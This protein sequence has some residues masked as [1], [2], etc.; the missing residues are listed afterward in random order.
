MLLHR[1]NFLIVVLFSTITAN[2]TVLVNAPNPYP[3][4]V[5]GD[6]GI[7][8]DYA[9]NAAGAPAVGSVNTVKGYRVLNTSVNAAAD[10]VYVDVSSDATFTTGKTIG[11]TLVNLSSNSEITIAGAG[12][13]SGMGPPLDCGNSNCFDDGKAAIYTQSTTLRISF[14]LTALC[15]TVSGDLCTHYTTLSN[16]RFTQSI[17]VHFGVVDNATI[18]SSTVTAATGTGNSDLLSS[19]TLAVSD[20]APV[21]SSTSCPANFYF[22]GDT[23]IYFNTGL[24]TASVGAT[25]TNGTSGAALQYLIAMANEVSV[26]ATLDGSTSNAIISYAPYGQ[27]Q[28]TIAG[29]TNTTN[30]TDHSYLMIVQAQNRAGIISATGSS[31]TCSGVQS[32]NISGILNESKCFIATAAYQD[33]KAAPVMMLRKFR[34]QILSHFSIGRDFIKTYYTYSPALAEW[35]WDKPIIRSIALKALAPIELMAWVLLKFSSAEE[36]AAQESTQPYIDRLKKELPPEKNAPTSNE[37]YSEQE[38]KKLLENQ[39][40]SPSANESYIDRLKKKLAEEEKTEASANGYSEKEKNKLPATVDRESPITVVKEGRDHKLGRGEMPDIKNAAGFKFGIS[41]G[42]QVTVANSVHTFKDVYGSGFQPELM[43]H[44]ERQLFHSENFGSFGL[45]TDFGLAY[46][47]GQ[48][49]LQFGFNGSS[50]SITGFGF[51]QVPWIINATYRFNL[52]RILRPYITAGPGAI[53]Y[54]ETRNDT[55][56]DKRGYS[57]VYA[58]SLGTSILMDFLDSGTSRDSYLSNG[59]Q[60][61]YL[62]LEYLYLNTFK[63]TVTFKRAGIYSGF[64]FEF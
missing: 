12:I 58:G 11:V 55:K 49:L 23:Q 48:G 41:P 14:S 53:F 60:H 36:V 10:R 59:I 45:G 4:Y 24:F 43:F 8:I 30:L 28:Q 47:G 63:S 39:P 29:F 35:A 34:D 31:A 57:A 44:Y 17:A 62:F 54:T 16:D 9:G 27:S 26:A 19:F 50:Q 61:T 25:G 3:Q 32:Q 40:L 21:M 18:P 22:P 7:V 13:V 5:M 38:R 1:F 46:S 20:I 51:F 52:L 37:S 56:G 15:A 42:M 2:A 33:G 64:L 6:T